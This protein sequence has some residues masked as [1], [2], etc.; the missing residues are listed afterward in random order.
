M[1]G[2]G[3]GVLGGSEPPRARE[4]AAFMQVPEES[5]QTN[6]LTPVAWKRVVRLVLPWPKIHLLKEKV[7][8][9]VHAA[10]YAVTLN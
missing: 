8:R 6:S 2:I 7:H 10:N 4:W 3:T 9:P 1:A 5:V